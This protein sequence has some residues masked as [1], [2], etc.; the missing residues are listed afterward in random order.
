MNKINTSKYGF[1][2]FLS[3]R[4]KVNNLEEAAKKYGG[5]THNFD[6]GEMYSNVP[7]S[8]FIELRKAPKLNT[9]SVFIPSTDGTYE[10][11]APEKLR[12]VKAEIIS[13]IYKRYEEIPSIERGI[14]S[15]QAEDGGIA[16]DNLIIAS[17]HIENVTDDDIR[18]FVRL[19]QYIKRE[20]HQES[21]SIA[22]NDA[23]ALV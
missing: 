14:G 3:G 11:A 19:G 16:Y 21:V 4:V 18:F 9:L 12:K 13:R 2:Y 22:I 17:V 8:E 15:Y 1:S 23:L 7:G 10:Q 5:A 6:T 20:L